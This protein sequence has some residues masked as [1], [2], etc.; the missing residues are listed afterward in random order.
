MRPPLVS[1][2]LAPALALCCALATA[3][4]IA[5][6]RHAVCKDLD[7][8]LGVGISSFSAA[9]NWPVVASQQHGV[10]WKFL[11]LYV[12]PTQSPPADLQWFLRDKAKLARS[13]GAIPVYTFYELLLLGQAKGLTGTEPQVVQ[14][15]LQDA[16]ADGPSA[17]DAA[18][19]DASGDHDAPDASAS[20]HAPADGSPSEGAAGAAGSTGGPAAPDPASGPGDAGCGCRSGARSRSALRAAPLF[21]L[22]F[23]A[24]RR[25]ARRA[26]DHDQPTTPKRPFEVRRPA[27]NG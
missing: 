24:A 1:T 25:R 20:G 14:K 27:A 15:A 10:K 4:S 23:L 2:S 11:Y 8:S 13:L 18:A 26:L 17:G 6:P 12:V 21:A 7:P 16:A 5:A 9:G 19:A 22:A 3:P